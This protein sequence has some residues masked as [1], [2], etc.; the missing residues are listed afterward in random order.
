MSEP[1]VAFGVVERQAG[2]GSPGARVFLSAEEVGELTERV[3]EAG[4]AARDEPGLPLETCLALFESRHV[5]EDVIRA[6]LEDLVRRRELRLSNVLRHKAEELE[7]MLLSLLPRLDAGFLSSV[8]VP[9]GTS[10]R[11]EWLVYDIAA[12]RGELEVRARHATGAGERALFTVLVRAAR[13]PSRWQRWLRRRPGP[14]RRVAVLEPAGLS[15]EDL[16]A[17]A[18]AG[19]EGSRERLV[20]VAFERL[21]EAILGE[22]E[23]AMGFVR[24]LR[25]EGEP[26]PERPSS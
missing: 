17:S 15:L 21:R 22:V 12:E 1:I 3:L 26:G 2:G 24:D 18:F 19:G 14:R 23:R 4:S 7:R 11:P 25:F 13:P 6:A 5:P 9:L 8:Q 20:G 10:V 16:L